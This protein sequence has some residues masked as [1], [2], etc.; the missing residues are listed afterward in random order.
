MLDQSGWVVVCYERRLTHWFWVSRWAGGGIGAQSHSKCRRWWR[1]CVRASTWAMWTD[2]NQRRMTLNTNLG[3]SLLSK[4]S[5]LLDVVTVT[6][7]GVGV[8][9]VTSSLHPSSFPAMT[10]CC[11]FNT[12]SLDH[13]QGSYNSKTQLHDTTRSIS[14][15]A[16]VRT[17]RQRE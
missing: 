9:L 2:A 6:S 4:A 1:G 8:N 15:L 7:N 5:M 17:F 16:V 13:S 12:R 10:P 3:S 11:Q 14:N